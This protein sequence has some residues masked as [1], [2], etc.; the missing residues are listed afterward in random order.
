MGKMTTMWVDKKVR[1]K[2]KEVAKIM[3]EELRVKV[4]LNRAALECAE[5]W[6]A[7]KTKVKA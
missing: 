7:H 1:D 3:S 4:P 6:L 5:F 2:I